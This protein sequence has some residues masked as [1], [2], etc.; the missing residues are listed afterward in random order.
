[1]GES[2]LTLGIFF[3]IIS[4]FSWGVGDYIIALVV[5]RIGN[6]ASSFWTHLF[7]LAVTVAFMLLAQVPSTI[8][9]LGIL[10]SLVAS[11]LLVVGALAFFKG[12][13]VGKISLVSPI[14]SGYSIIPVAFAI[15]VFGEKI[16][17]VQLLA[18]LIIIVGTLLAATDIA[19]IAKTKRLLFKDLGVPYALRAFV[20][21]GFGFIL[22]DQ[23]VNRLGWIL[24]SVILFTV[25]PILSY[26]ISIFGHR[27]MRK[28][29]TI[30]IWLM[31]AVA[32]ILLA[33]AFISFS[34][35]VDTA[36]TSVVVPVSAAYPMITVLLAWL[37]AKEKLAQSQIIG[38]G[39][40]VT[41]LVLLNI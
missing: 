25:F 33:V 27:P 19:E 23:A 6:I 14:S 37:L 39:S 26:F 24:P 11:V 38:V 10:I 12:F 30:K 15:L 17:P 22:I 31:T 41:G 29:K 34:V 16:S 9:P 40:I 32:G 13:E 20:L 2:T 1:M 4:L 7:S 35:G 18:I 3:G 21:W 5:R 8:D 28:P 36:L